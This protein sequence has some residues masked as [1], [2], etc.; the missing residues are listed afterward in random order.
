[1]AHEKKVKASFN[2]DYMSQVKKDVFIANHKELA[3][4]G[5]DLQS[6]WNEYNTK[7]VED[8]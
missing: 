6:V 2:K 5:V 4:L 1:M 7:K 3:T 8:K